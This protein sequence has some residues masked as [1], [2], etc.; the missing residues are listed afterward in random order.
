MA[1]HLPI[2]RKLSEIF[3]EGCSLY[4]SFDSFA[5]PMTSTEYQVSKTK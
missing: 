4:L 3:E 5:A 2:D 1:D